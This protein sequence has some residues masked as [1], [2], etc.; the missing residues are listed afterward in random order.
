M[1]LWALR[2]SLFAPTFLR[3]SLCIVAVPAWSKSIA[4]PLEQDL[5]TWQ[6]GQAYAFKAINAFTHSRG[7]DAVTS[8][9]AIAPVGSKARGNRAEVPG[10]GV[11]HKVRNPGGKG[12]CRL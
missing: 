11:F 12:I 10:K 5:G 4:A 8:S 9:L 1:C 6:M 7:A 3:T 2:L